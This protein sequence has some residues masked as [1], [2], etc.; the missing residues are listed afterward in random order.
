MQEPTPQPLEEHDRSRYAWQ[1]DV[2]DFGEEGQS[3]LKGASV[4][5]TRCGGLGSPVAYELAAAGVGRIILAHGGE[6]K[7]SDLNRQLL[8]KDSALGSSRVECAAERLREFA[9]K[10][11]VKAV[12]SNVSTE[13]AME[14]VDQADLV[15]DCAPM[16]EERFALNDAC[17]K[18]GKPMVEC[19]MYELQATITTLVPGRTPCLRCLVPEVPPAWTR[20]FPVFGAVSGTVGCLAAMEAIKILAGFGDP[21][22]GRMLTM[23]LRDM[24]FAN[25]S[26]DGMPRCSHCVS[27]D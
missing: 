22:L 14:L 16:F 9:P 24:S 8:M 10:L 26:L 27:I 4:L 17:L 21:L 18:L 7:T 5:V 15:V 11:D 12:P 1:I 23:N 13:N 3:R 25:T 19:A 2:P 6:L 20:R